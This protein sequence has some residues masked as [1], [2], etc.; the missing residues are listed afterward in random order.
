MT[1][2]AE[3]EHLFAAAADRYG[4]VDI[5]VSNAGA[6]VPIKP[7]AGVSEAEYDSATAIN[8]KANFFVL[9]EAARKIRDNGRIVVITSTTVITPYAGSAIFAG[10]KGAAEVYAR[11]LAREVGARGIT[12]NAL[13]P[14]PIDTAT[15]RAAGRIEDRFVAAI[16]MTPLGRIGTPDDIAAVVAFIVGE[17]GRWI[18]GQHLR[19]GGGII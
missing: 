8:A 4:G 5:V 12:V 6:P 3:I 17:G 2:I 9:R 19:V 7:I 18:T 11:V 1:R 16:S 13:A 10:A 15:A 14:G